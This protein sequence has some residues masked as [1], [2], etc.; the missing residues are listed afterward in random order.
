MLV[1]SPEVVF[2]GSLSYTKEYS[3]RTLQPNLLAR[4]IFRR[5]KKSFTSILLRNKKGVFFSIVKIYE[6]LLLLYYLNRNIRFNNVLVEQ[7]E[8]N[9]NKKRFE[10]FSVRRSCHDKV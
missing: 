9:I 7:R 4:N 3:C 5:T 10:T 2:V 1:Q 8:Q 6:M